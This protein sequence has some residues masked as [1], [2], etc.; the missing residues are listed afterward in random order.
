MNIQYFD[1]IPASN[2]TLRLN[3]KYGTNQALQYITETSIAFEIEPQKY[4]EAW[5]Y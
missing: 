4:Y 5:H 3:N 2:I 1:N